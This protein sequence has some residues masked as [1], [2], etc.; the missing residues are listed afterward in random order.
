MGLAVQLVLSGLAAGALYGLV[1]LGFSLVHRLGLV[2][3]FAHGDLMTFAIFAFLFGLAGG[4]PV[5]LGEAGAGT[6]LLAAAFAIL[7]TVVAAGAIQRVAVT[8]FLAGRGALGWI[9]GTAAAGL[10]LRS[11][12]VALFPQES[13]TVPDPLPFQLGALQIGQG[14]LVQLRW[15]AILA[16]ALLLSLAVDRWLAGSRAGKAMRATALD[17]EAAGLCGISAA[18]M[19]L[20]AWGLAGALV[21]TAGL[22]LAPERPVTVA[23][24]V[25]LGV[26][27]VA[28]AVVGGLDSTVGAVV[29]GLGIGLAEALL[30]AAATQFYDVFAVALLVAVLAL[31]PRRTGLAA[32][33]AE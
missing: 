31:A 32:E 28:A 26:K 22:L 8:P 21:A 18:R 13:Y 33:P 12:A 16:I 23:L 9:A 1:G 3:N 11:A 29:A 30:G 17:P 15:L 6:L 24:G 2:L 20:L 7:L 27:G 5:A 10:L 4:A 19:R 25:T 14:N